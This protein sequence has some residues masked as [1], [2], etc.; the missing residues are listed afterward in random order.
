MYAASLAVPA[1]VLALH[2][3][4][5]PQ[6]TW[7]DE[8][9]TFGFFRENG[10]HGLLYRFYHWSPRPLSEALI[11]LYWLAVQAAHRPL[12][13]PA[14]VV[15]WAMAG[16]FLGLAVAPWQRPGRT[17]R[18]A[19]W[20]TLPAAMLLC[21]PIG[22]LYYWPLGA[23]A[24]LPALGAAA[25]CA[26]IAAGPG[27]RSDR[28]F[29]AVAGLLVAGAASVELGAFLAIC[30]TPALLAIA[31]RSRR[32]ARVIAAGTPLLAGG[33]ALA[34]LLHGRVAVGGEAMTQSPLL[35]HIWP[36]LAA[37]VRRAVE[38]AVLG[39]GD[40]AAGLGLGAAALRLL[41]MGLFAAGVYL[42]MSRAWPLPPHRPAAAGVL[43]GL[44]G[45]T[46]LSI[47][48]A[49]YEFGALCCE[50]HASYRQALLLLMLVAACGIM[51]RRAS[52]RW[53]PNWPVGALL[54]AAS[55]LPAWPQRL[56][57]LRVE[58]RLGASRAEATAATF[59]S[60]LAPG[61]GP[62]RF[63]QKPDGPLLHFVVLP[64]GAYSLASKP[65]WPIAGP[66]IFFG[67]DRMSVEQKI[68]SHY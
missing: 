41:A 39:A 60:G 51:P 65:G 46:L 52:W 48:T 31:L 10:L 33:A 14:L 30:C 1:I 2:I 9:F 38:E 18:L 26:V 29:W 25:G 7:R 11:W 24:Y 36:S 50:R 47:A 16:L 53:Q 67:K 44:A 6:G 49:Y 23:L 21:G 20:L 19:L 58:Y 64:A 54:L 68:A 32:L 56:A 4:L 55:L 22:N 57:G 34:M 40:D 17:A 63:V 37:A 12:V 42:C 3:R 61:S 8:Y 62:L 66:M 45:T 15:A 13:A 35:H 5:L 43:I 28:H 59:A 27:L